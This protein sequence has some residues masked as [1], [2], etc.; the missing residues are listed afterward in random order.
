MKDVQPTGKN[1]CREILAA[2]L[3]PAH[4]PWCTLPPHHLDADE[5]EDRLCVSAEVAIPLALL[6]VIGD[7]AVDDC[8]LGVAVREQR[9]GDGFAVNIPLNGDYGLMLTPAE[10]STL[11]H[12]VGAAIRMVEDGKVARVVAPD[13]WMARA[14]DLVA[15]AEARPNA[16]TVL[17]F[18]LTNVPDVA[19]LIA[20]LRPILCRTTYGMYGPN[21]LLGIFDAGLESIGNLM[22]RSVRNR[23]A[24][25]G[26]AVG[27]YTAIGAGLPEL[28]GGAFADM[29]VIDADPAN[30]PVDDQPAGVRLCPAP[31]FWRRVGNRLAGR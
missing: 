28:L 26:I 19:E 13:T 7:R 3:A 21:T 29:R 31:G 6:Q 10:A 24:G 2:A 18:D 30:E 5:P 25:T 8:T 4:M 9:G 17:V 27:C 20:P 1:T 22:S 11:V 23:M 16:V 15:A 14:E 12:N